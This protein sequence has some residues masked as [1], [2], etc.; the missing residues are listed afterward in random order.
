MRGFLAGVLAVSACVANGDDP[1]GQ[2][3]Q[4]LGGSD[5]CS[6]PSQCKTDGNGGGSASGDPCAQLDATQ[7]EQ[8][9]PF[10][11]AVVD[12]PPCDKS[13]DP[14]G[15]TDTTM[16]SERPCVFV[17]CRSALPADRCAGLNEQACNETSGC[18]GSYATACTGTTDSMPDPNTMGCTDAN[19]P[20]GCQTCV[21]LFSGCH[22]DAACGADSTKP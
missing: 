20:D 16:C 17:A 6:D 5:Q 19:K 7:C 12:C 9:A 22:A 10:C 11:E 18:Q 3:Q 8:K 13:T 21:R 2:S 4:R 14:A 1:S 15:T